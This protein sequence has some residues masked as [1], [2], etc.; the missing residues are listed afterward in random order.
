MTGAFRLDGVAIPFEEGDS[1][2]AA[3]RRAGRYIPHLCQDERFPAH[4]S[5]K[6][7]VVEIGGRHVSACATAAR[8]GLDVK[9]DIA[10][11]RETRRE[12][13]VMLFAEGNHFCP[14]CEK[15]GNCQL[16]AL[17][18]DLEA[19]T[20]Q[21]NFFYPDRPVDASHPDLLLDFNR[22]IFCELCVRASRDIDGKEIFSL[23]ERGVN[24]R[25]VVNAESGRL[26]DTDMDV[27]DLAANICPVGVILHK[28]IGFAVP[29]GARIYDREPISQLDV[30]AA[31][32]ALEPD[33][34]PKDD[35]A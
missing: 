22:C 19:M 4:G 30:A 18:Y 24:K 27:G 5:C 32:C 31:T 26:G 8:D 9:N 3:A 7:C 35:G 34:A 29:I 12:L 25:L 17:A 13:L 1:V 11:I 20:P 6:V 21:H 15:S 16:Q 14:G 23:S 10:D 2:L 33:G 28:R